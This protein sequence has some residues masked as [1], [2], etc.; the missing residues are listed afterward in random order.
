MRITSHRIASHR[1]DKTNSWQTRYIPV[2]S[3][4]QG[5]GCGSHNMQ[6]RSVADASAAR[7]KHLSDTCNT[8]ETKQKQRNTQQRNATQQAWRGNAARTSGPQHLKFD[9]Q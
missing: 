9:L 2:C 3:A 4:G 6:S 5:V 1:I 8:Q 7:K